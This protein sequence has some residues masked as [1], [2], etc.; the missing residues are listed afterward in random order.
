MTEPLSPARLEGLVLS[1]IRTDADLLKA[2]RLGI[3]EDHFVTPDHARAWAYLK[4][5]FGKGETPS[6][7]DL[8][9]MGCEVTEGIEDLETWGRQLA[10]EVLRAKVNNLLYATVKDSKLV[11]DPRAA[12]NQLLT[13]LGELNDVSPTEGALF[14]DGD[15]A[16]LL[17]EVAKRVDMKDKAMPVGIP[18]GLSFFDDDGW[19]WQRG[20]VVAIMGALGIGKSSLL[21]FSCCSAYEAG[22]KILYLSPESTQE[23]IA[24]RTHVFLSKLDKSRAWKFKR[25]ELHKGTVDL[26]EF[27]EWT[28][29]LKARRDWAVIDSG[30]RGAFSLDEVMSLTRQHRPDVLAI[31]GFHLIQ[32]ADRSQTWEQVRDAAIRLKGLAQDTGTVI[33]S[34]CQTTRDALQWADVMPEAH[35]AAYGAKALLEAADRVLGLAKHGAQKQIRRIG[36]VKFRDGPDMLGQDKLIEF[37]PDD[38]I[39]RETAAV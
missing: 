4:D 16:V 34:V 39:F 35:Q 26:E 18:T 8:Q 23:E 31:D 14:L 3:T 12:V 33:L 25:S 29:K 2:E 21:A 7:A 20:E 19:T 1:A 10:D 37:L 15:A 9:A 27:E 22:Y 13:S 6:L 38:G 17:D 24:L 28:D 32:S 30:A 11:N 36:V 5:R